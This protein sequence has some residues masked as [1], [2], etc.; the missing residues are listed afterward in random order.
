[1]EQAGHDR[2]REKG[3]GP[4]HH[5]DRGSQYLSIRF[6]ERLAEAGFEPLVGSM[7][8]GHDTALV[9]AI[10]GLFKAGA[11]HRRGTLRSCEVVEFGVDWINNR[12][13]HEPIGAIPPAEAGAGFH[14]ALKNEAFAAEQTKISLRRTRRGS[15]SRFAAVRSRLIPCLIFDGMLV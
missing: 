8:D 5:G 2:R 7:G 11:F 15:D 14:A 1:L 9:E 13:V 10:E 12:R 3:M 4:V 6:S